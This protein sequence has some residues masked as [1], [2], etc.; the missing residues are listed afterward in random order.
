MGR[1]TVEIRQQSSRSGAATH[2]KKR[3]LAQVR[4]QLVTSPL[5]RVAFAF[6]WAW[7]WAWAPQSYFVVT[8]E[9]SVLVLTAVMGRGVV[10][11]VSC[12]TS[13]VLYKKT[14]HCCASPCPF[15]TGA[16][17]GKDELLPGW[18]AGGMQ[19]VHPLQMPQVPGSGP[20]TQP[21]E[22]SGS[23]VW[24]WPIASHIGASRRHR[25]TQMS[26][27]RTSKCHCQPHGRSSA[28]GKSTRRR[29]S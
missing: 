23:A 7:A 28:L 20:V 22:Q 11:F 2:E 8:L 15:E 25:S 18:M 27:A 6:P 29:G 21:M 26:N 10:R 16:G 5:R 19:P 9:L 4:G 17:Q 24:V 12:D 13:F 3:R 14:K 1:Y